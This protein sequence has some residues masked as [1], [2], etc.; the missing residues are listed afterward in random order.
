MLV[1]V[2]VINDMRELDLKSFSQLLTVETV[3]VMFIIHCYAPG[4]AVVHEYWFDYGFV[5]F[6]PDMSYSVFPDPDIIQVMKGCC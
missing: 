5:K 6:Q 1:E 3:K 4:L 2:T